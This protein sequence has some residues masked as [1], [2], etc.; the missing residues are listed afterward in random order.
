M[1]GGTGLTQQLDDSIAN[2]IRSRFEETISL[3]EL[4]VSGCKVS[5]LMVIQ[6]LYK[7]RGY[8]PIWTNVEDVKQLIRTIQET[9]LEG[10]NPDDYHLY[11]I[12]RLQAL[13]NEE[14]NVDIGV[15]ASLDLLLSDAF[16]RLTFHSICG[17]EDP[18]TYHPQWNLVREIHGMDPV[19]FI[20]ERIISPSIARTIQ[21]VKVHPPYYEDL[22][23]VLAEYRTLRSRGGWEAVPLGPALKKGMVDPRVAAIRKRLAII[24]ILSDSSPDPMAFDEILEVAV[25]K[26]QYRHGLKPDGVV[27]RATLK[28]MNVPVDDRI[29]QIRVNLERVR[30]IFHGPD[31]RFVLVDIAG[32]RV[33]FYE[34]NKVIWASRAQVG[35]PYRNTPVFKSTIQHIELNPSW[36]VPPGI[37]KKDTLPAVLKDLSYLERNDLS[38]IDNKGAVV[39]PNTI[40][41]KLYTSRP[42]PYRLRQDPGEKSTLG[43]IKIFFPNDYLVYLH[44]TPN[45]A[46][47][48][49]EERAFSS[50][51]IRVEKPL[52]LAELL[53]NDPLRWSLERITQT[54]KSDKNQRV[55][56]PRP[57]TILLMY[58][59]VEVDGE[60][61]IFKK[62]PYNRDPLVLEGLGRDAD[63]RPITM[64]ANKI[65]GTAV[66][67]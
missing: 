38:V 57:V 10:L 53:L 31:D 15:A 26:F 25:K 56:L 3:G 21:G 62:D 37:F 60:G 49:R 48:E 11:H 42:F 5:S 32:F 61:V 52:E 45:K 6:E 8:R 18:V 46:L 24:D 23:K 36:V 12:Q 4:N 19:K 20:E 9:Y 17:K 35:Q 51:C 13:I 27:G 58:W 33:L 66:E 1:P 55:S 67:F 50:G 47:F 34:K 40:N 28:E 54:A 41:W 64:Q 29:D 63:I 14:T 59:T 30:W 2:L 22:K 7:G 43:R 39:D 65:H 16:I 44:D